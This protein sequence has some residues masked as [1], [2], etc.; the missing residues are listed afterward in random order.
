M[1]AFL[2]RLR[3]QLDKAA[4]KKVEKNIAKA[5]T[6]DRYRDLA[7]LTAEILGREDVSAIEI[8]AAAFATV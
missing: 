1:E 4:L 3:G 8:P 6:R 2:D 7:K 5:R